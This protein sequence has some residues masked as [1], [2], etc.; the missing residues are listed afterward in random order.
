GRW[1]VITALSM[2]IL[3]TVWT[4]A[5]GTIRPMLA[6][7]GTMITVGWRPTRLTWRRPAW[8]TR[9]RTIRPA[10]AASATISWP[11]RST[12]ARAESAGA[13]WP[14]RPTK[15]SAWARTLTVLAFDHLGNRLALIGRYAEICQDRFFSQQKS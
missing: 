12:G 9:W 11:A 1:P 6:W 15:K 7:T 8:F 14:A 13:T 3:M 10:K 5:P 2:L 4:V